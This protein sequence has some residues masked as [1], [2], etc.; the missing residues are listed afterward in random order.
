MSTTA[1]VR[2]AAR[3][4]EHSTW[5]EALTRIGFIGYGLLH[6]AIAWLAIQVA[7]NHAGT[8]ADQVGAFQLLKNEPAGH[9]L[10]IIIAIGLGAMALW[11]FI[12]AAVGHRNYHGKRRAA[13][14]LVSL[15]RVVI[16]AFLLWTDVKVLQGTATSGSN[17]QERATAGLLAHPS[18][19]WLV[20]L[21]GL[22]V[23]G[24][25]IGM[26]VYGLKRKFAAKLALGSARPQTRKAILRLGQVGYVAKAI[27][28]GIVGGLLFDAALSDRAS[29]SKGL[30]GAL[31]TL[32]SEP[33]GRVLLFVI[34][35][36][37]AA[38]GV[39]CFAQSRYR[40]I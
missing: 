33:L 6:L 36:G 5:L 3:R 12:L 39:Y 2:S 23:L 26:F 16:Y 1:S 18:G 31:R 29:R 27:A 40:K 30:D 35:I 9:A 25:G 21:A 14:R 32:A 15:A 24:I 38:F 34:A 10:L 13:E 28:F 19:R 11:Q 37:F 17:S 8:S 7:L 20:A 4:A 22:V